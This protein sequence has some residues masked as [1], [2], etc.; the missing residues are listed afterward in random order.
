MNFSFVFKPYQNLDSYVVLD[1]KHNYANAQTINFTI[2]N[3]FEILEDFNLT[4]FGNV[5]DSSKE[6]FLTSF[7]NIYTFRSPI[8]P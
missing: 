7:T 3:H 8:P 6:H 5:S 2:T 4:V 1:T